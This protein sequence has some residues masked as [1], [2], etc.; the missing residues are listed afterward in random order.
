MTTFEFLIDVFGGEYLNF[1][2]A[3]GTIMYP[4]KNYLN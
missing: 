1:V 4:L 2:Q 3:V